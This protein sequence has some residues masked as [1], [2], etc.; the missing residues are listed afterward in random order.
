MS[1]DLRKYA[2]GKPCLIRVP[3]VCNHNPETTVLCHL[4]GAGL[5]VKH[6]DLFGAWGCSNCHD[7]V[8]GRMKLPLKRSYLELLHYE[9][10]K[11]T[12]QQLLIDGVIH[13]GDPA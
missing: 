8:D 1:I 10:M 3:G 11:R 6:H 4:N 9:G 12:Q 7:A 13:I 2:M 5:A